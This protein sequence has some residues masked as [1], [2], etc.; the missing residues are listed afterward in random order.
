LEHE[1]TGLVFEAGDV[2]SLA[3]Q[4]K[5]VLAE[6]QLGDRLARR[7]RQRIEQSFDIVRAVDQIEEFLYDNM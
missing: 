4:L 6:P 3:A 5:R 1:N 2:A 7:A